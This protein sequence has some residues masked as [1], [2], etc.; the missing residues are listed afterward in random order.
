MKGITFNNIHSYTEW[1]LL[2]TSQEVGSPSIKLEEVDKQG[3][4]GRLDFTDYFSGV[5]YDN[6]TLKFEF[7]TNSLTP[8]EF[9]E[10][11]SDIQDKLHGQLMKVVLDDDT[12]YFY[13]GRVKVGD[14]SWTK[15][16]GKVVVEVEAEPYKLKKQLTTVVKAVTGTASITLTNSRKPVVPQITTTASMTVAFNGSVWAVGAGTSKIPELQLEEGDNV[17]TVTGTGNI[18]FEYQEGRL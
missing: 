1:G 5:K 12:G 4:D 13:R 7:S 10:L 14:F 9:L 17:L 18:T 16:L 15:W 3:A 6:R 8:A 2:L 11:V